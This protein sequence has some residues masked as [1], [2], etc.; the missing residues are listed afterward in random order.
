MLISYRDAQVQ[1]ISNCKHYNFCTIFQD[2][3]SMVSLVDDLGSVPSNK[4]ISAVAI[5]NLYAF[6]LNRYT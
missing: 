1:I 2:Y 6:A 3:D 4:I 5:Q